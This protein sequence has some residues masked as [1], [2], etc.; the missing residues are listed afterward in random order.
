[1]S[2][3]HPSPFRADCA[4]GLAVLV[5]GGGSGIGYGICTAF[6]AHGAKVAMFGRRQHVLKESC[7]SLA[8]KYPSAD[9]L[10]LTGDVRSAESCAAAIAAMVERYGRCDVLVNAAAGNFMSR[11]EDLG[12]KGMRTVL[13]IDTLGTFNMSLAALPALSLTL[14][15][16]PVPKLCGSPLSEPNPRT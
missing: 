14:K 12:S 15:P 5:T 13:E 9:P 7:A 2:E 6:A 16:R 8:A 1:M 10:A 4:A 11:A 3:E